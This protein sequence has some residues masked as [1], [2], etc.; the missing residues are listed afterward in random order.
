[1]LQPGK[2]KL[3]VGRI[4][5]PHGVKGELNVELDDLAEPDEDFAPGACLILEIDGLDVPFFVAS[6]RPRGSASILLTLDEVSSESEAAALV[7]QT[8]YVYS[9][10]EDADVDGELTAGELVG[11]EIIDEETGS[12]IGVVEEL[13]E[14]TADNWYFSLRDSGKLIPAVDEMILQINSGSRTILMSLPAGLLDL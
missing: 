2:I 6:A 9:D 7:G 12:S 10:P 3:P 5:K 1:M 4:L 8:L 11:Y 14:L 13:I